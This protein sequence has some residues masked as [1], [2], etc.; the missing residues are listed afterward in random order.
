MHSYEVIWSHEAVYDIADIV[1]YIE[2]WFG[3]E[4]ADRFLRDIDRE[5]EVLGSDFRMYHDT[6]FY[7]GQKLILKKVFA[8]SI[9]FFF[10]NDEEKCVYILRILRQE[11]DWQRILK[12]Q[13]DGSFV[14]LVIETKE[15]FPFV[16]N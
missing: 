3:R 6:G 14:L 12:R 5:R 1:D 7:Y 11:R 4:R 8:P 15:P 13:G 16:N 10:V 9:I 2:L